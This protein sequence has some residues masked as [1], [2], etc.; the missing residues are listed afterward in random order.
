VLTQRE[1]KNVKEKMANYLVFHAN[2]QKNVV[3][4]L[5]VSQC[6]H[7]VRHI[8]IAKFIYCNYKIKMLL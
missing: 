2:L 7:H 1:P 4:I 5:R 3:R 8:N 6:V